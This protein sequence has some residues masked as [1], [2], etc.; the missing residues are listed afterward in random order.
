MNRPTPR[1]MEL[2]KVMFAERGDIPE[3]AA[4]REEA[5]ASYRAGRLNNEAVS[6]LITN[7]RD[8]FPVRRGGRVAASQTGGPKGGAWTEVPDG[9][10]AVAS[11]TG[12]NDLDFW[13][14][15][16]AGEDAGEWAGFRRVA[17]VIGGHADV[18]VK[19][20]ERTAA[21]EAILAAGIDEARMTYAREN[22]R[23]WHCNTQLTDETSRALGVGPV[24]RRNLGMTAPA[25]ER[26]APE[27]VPMFEVVGAVVVEAPEAE[28]VEA[29]VREARRVLDGAAARAEVL[30][31]MRNGDLPTPAWG[32]RPW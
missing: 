29:E 7:L 20:R 2:L 15:S 22:I 23:C 9:Y 16:T 3:V 12:N 21:L 30:A 6:N 10:Y 24:C 19:G 31:A 28:A 27:P 17:R 11:R 1:Q 13:F 8:R 32:S 25:P 26:V 14:V 4:I 5:L 18:R